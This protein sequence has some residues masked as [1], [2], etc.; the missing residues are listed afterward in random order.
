MPKVTPVRSSKRSWEKDGETNYAWTFTFATEDGTSIDADTFAQPCADA[1]EANIGTGLEVT[2]EPGKEYRGKPTY[3]IT[4]VAKGG[5]DLYRKAS[6]GYNGPRGGGKRSG[7]G[8]GDWETGAERAVRRQME[9]QRDAS[10]QAECALERATQLAIAAWSDSVQKGRPLAAEMQSF[11]TQ[12]TLELAA[13][14][15]EAAV[16]RVLPNIVVAAP[17]APAPAPVTAPVQ[18]VR[19]HNAESGQ[20]SS[21]GTDAPTGI[22]EARNAALAKH[23]GSPRAV[24][25]AW[26]AAG[27]EAKSFQLLTSEELVE[28]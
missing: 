18:E 14:L 15:R 1:L 8:G 17:E 2:T 6:G 19:T 28:V 26:T 9:A 23:G 11:V 21:V 3:R 4:A 20:Q 7:G 10:I 27:R 5:A 24:E 12:C 13:V 16:P 25:A 22:H